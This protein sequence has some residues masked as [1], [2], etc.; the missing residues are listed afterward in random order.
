[1]SKNISIKRKYK[2]VNKNKNKTQKKMK[3]GGKTKTKIDLLK[4][5][6]SWIGR[7]TYVKEK[8][9]H[10]DMFIKDNNAQTDTEEFI[11]ADFLIR[12]ANYGQYATVDKLY[13][14]LYEYCDSRYKSKSLAMNCWQFVLLCL[15]ESQYLTEEQIQ[16]LYLHYMH[17]PDKEKRLP[18]YFGDEYSDT[19]VPGDIIL[20]KRDNGKGHIWHI[21]ILKTIDSEYIEYIEM[22]GLLVNVVKT[23]YPPRLSDNNLSTY[24]FQ[25]DKMLFIT[26]EK[27][28]APIMKLKPIRLQIQPATY[29]KIHLQKFLIYIYYKDEIFKYA[30]KKWDKLIASGDINFELLK[31]LNPLYYEYIKSRPDLYNSNS[32]KEIVKKNLYETFAKEFLREHDLLGLVE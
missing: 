20:F 23:E 2:Y 7:G 21:G 13:K 24:R 6:E 3:G 29:N 26:P 4:A 16:V 12:F 22:L 25:P 27:F 8:G 28:I 9:T 5:A 10:M 18:D 19:G 11:P 1:M 31:T 30:T 17:N 32:Y 14:I 15:L